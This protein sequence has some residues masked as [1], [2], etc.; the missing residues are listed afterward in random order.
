MKHAQFRSLYGNI[1]DEDREILT[2]DMLDAMIATDGNDDAPAM[3]PIAKA[4]HDVSQEARGQPDNAG[5]WVAG[6]PGAKAPNVATPIPVTALNTMRGDATVDK[7]PVENFL[8]DKDSKPLRI[9]V[10]DLKKL[11]F[12]R[13]GVAAKKTDLA[14]A[15][16]FDRTVREDLQPQLIGAEN[17]TT[18]G[19][20]TYGARLHAMSESAIQRYLA[21][22]KLI[23]TDKFYSQWCH[24]SAELGK[25][26]GISQ[27][28]IVAALS[29]LS[30]GTTAAYN[31][32]YG[33]DMAH[34]VHDNTP[35]LD[36]HSGDPSVDLAAAMFKRSVVKA[37]KDTAKQYA[38]KKGPGAADLSKRLLY[39]VK[40]INSGQ[41]KSIGDLPGDAA[42]R[43]AH[44]FRKSSL[45]QRADIPYDPR[46]GEEYTKLL[47]PAGKP[48]D[49]PEG[50][51]GFGV[52]KG[53]LNYAK[54][55]NVL[56]GYDVIEGPDGE[57][58]QVPFSPSDAV[59]QVKTRNFVNNQLDPDD[60][61]GFDSV[62]VD[63]H[64]MNMASGSLGGADG[65]RSSQW[66]SG[67]TVAGVQ[68]GIRAHV[69][70]AIR[71]EVPFF[72]KALNDPT[73]SAARA[74]E[75]LWAEWKRGLE[76]GT[77]KWDPKGYTPPVWR[78]FDG[79]AHPLLDLRQPDKEEKKQKRMKNKVA[80]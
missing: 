40:L 76:P 73:L 11:A 25:E 60:L 13:P 31:L 51:A 55:T 1:A 64:G 79:T 69:A 7:R 29:N 8:T 74:Q 53:Y 46:M 39:A 68:L 66:N 70:D 3:I 6:A 61:Q 24:V 47:T 9:S 44:L 52:S 19:I 28:R 42:A 71:A 38:A 65:D 41:A 10:G 48:G 20:D 2:A 21:D 30:A 32:R 12:T 72:R 50:H 56:R 77:T 4:G 57:P 16:D 22:P 23:D 33:A 78:A 35:W 67:A 54:A 36:M 18:N 5:E 14:S 15:A 80:L 26:T 58:M 45:F 62:T 37:L 75:I 63:Y 34:I 17:I 59:Q 49:L 43:Y 27:D